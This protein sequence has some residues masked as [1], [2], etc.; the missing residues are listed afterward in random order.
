MNGIL[1]AGNAGDPPA[2][3][4]PRSQPFANT[5]RPATNKACSRFTLTQARQPAFPAGRLRSIQFYSSVPLTPT[6]TEYIA[7]SVA[8]IIFPFR[9]KQT[10]TTFIP[11]TICSIS[12]GSLPILN[13]PRFPP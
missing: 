12:S 13:T 5:Q 4:R 9:V 11:A 7:E 3:T 6:A 2:R 10:P 1:P 8:T